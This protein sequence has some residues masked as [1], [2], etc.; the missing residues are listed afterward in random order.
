MVDRTDPLV[1]DTSESSKVR[2]AVAGRSLRR[3]ARSLGCAAC[4]SARASHVGVA[5]VASRVR[6]HTHVSP[7]LK[8][9]LLDMQGV[10]IHAMEVYFPRTAVKQTELEK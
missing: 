7:G 1:F 3:A 2:G 8:P 5:V 6:R 4:A 10:G 9:A